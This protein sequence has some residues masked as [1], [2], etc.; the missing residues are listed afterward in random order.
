MSLSNIDNLKS[1]SL[2]DNQR[3]VVLLKQLHR[4]Q[5]ITVGDYQ[6]GKIKSWNDFSKSSGFNPPEQILSTEFSS[7]NIREAFKIEIAKLESSSEIVEPPIKIPLTDW[8]LSVKEYEEL[9]HNYKPPKVKG[10]EADD[11]FS[12]IKSLRSNINVR[13]FKPQEQHAASILRHLI[14]HKH[15]ARALSAGVGTGKTFMLGAVIR[16][17][18]DRKWPPI[19]NSIS[20]F[21]ILYITRASVVTKTERDL[22]D[23]FGLR[24]GRDVYVTNI[25]QMRSKLGNELV[26]EEM[27][28]VDGQD[29]I[30]YT[31]FEPLAPALMILDEAHCVKNIDST[32]SRIM[33]RFNDL[34]G[35]HYSIYS[36]ATLFTRVIESKCFAVACKLEW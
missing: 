14:K 36:S 35:E 34:E 7:K 28:V 8:Q 5:Q 22:S 10:V 15:R 2:D 27:K 26:H 23:G 16:E 32:Q 29:R 19:L 24:I 11:E 12:I 33:Q 17:L 9:Y 31:W 30:V 4:Q 1:S 13:Y 21:P 20:P 3:R 6:L 25:D 18:I